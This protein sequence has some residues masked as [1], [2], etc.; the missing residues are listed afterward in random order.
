MI[1]PLTVT[2]N[3]VSARTK[4]DSWLET[5]VIAKVTNQDLQ[6]LFSLL[7]DVTKDITFA[8]R[9]LIDLHEGINND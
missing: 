9:E 2:N 1:I 6:D 3:L 7:Q 8:A 5:P 4:L